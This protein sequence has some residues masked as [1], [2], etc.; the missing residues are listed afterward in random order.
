[1]LSVGVCLTVLA[2][3]RAR[4]LA[5][6]G[7]AQIALVALVLSLPTLAASLKLL[8]VVKGAGP[9]DLGNLTAPIPA[10]ASTGVWISGDYR[11]PQYVH[12]GPSDVL[13]VLVLVLAACGLVFAIRRRA[14]SVVWLGVAGVVSLYYVAHRYGPWIQ[15]KAD[16]L[17]SPI[18]LLLAFA[19]VGAL[20]RVSRRVLVGALPALAIAAGVL[21]GNALLYHD[22]TLAPYARL[23]N[24]EYIGKR[25]AGKGPTLTPDFE[26]YAEYYLRDDNQT[27]MVNGPTLELRPGVNRA[28]EPGGIFAYDLNEFPLGWVESFRTIVMR[29]NPL[30]SRPPSNYRLVYLSPYYA[31]WQRDQPATTVYAHVPIADRPGYRDAA[32]CAEVAA[33]ARKSARLRRSPTCRRRRATSRLMEV[34]R[35]SAVRSTRPVVRSSATAPGAPFASSRSRRRDATTSS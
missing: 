13:A 7:C 34:T 18:S 17:T 8:P 26:E 10:I 4:V 24:L 35:R 33:S 3:Q 28:T 20:M 5:L 27:S 16:T 9:V 19:G 30:A 12:H 1:M 23:H 29:R 11:F 25:F 6:V 21:A 14:W 32:L 31:V 22:T 2:F 15:F